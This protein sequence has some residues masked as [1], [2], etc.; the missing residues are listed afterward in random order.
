[1]LTGWPAAHAD[2]TINTASGNGAGLILSATL[3]GTTVASAS[4]PGSVT[5]LGNTA[6]VTGGTAAVGSTTSGTPYSVSGS[7]ANL[8]LTGTTALAIPAHLLPITPLPLVSTAISA[9]TTLSASLLDA[10]ASFS[11]GTLVNSYGGVSD[12]KL[13]V[14][15]SSTTTTTTPGTPPMTL[16]GGLFLPPST[17]KTPLFS[18]GLTADALQS[19]SQISLINGLLQGTNTLN[20][21]ANVSLDLSSLISLT[22]LSLP[23]SSL[24]RSIN[25]STIAGATP[26]AN[27]TLGGSTGSLLASLGIMLT[28]NEQFNTCTSLLTSCS[29]ETNALHLIIDPAI[30]GLAA[31][32]L[33]L[34][35]S[36]A[37]ATV[38]AVPEPATYA[39]MGLGLVGVMLGARRQRRHACVASSVQ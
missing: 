16:P 4:L 17:V 30:A 14:G 15:L 32:D 21:F 18:L 20:S 13:G 28:L 34:G 24:N 2:A 8:T 9:T 36:Y 25:L 11:N 23:G 6:S 27:T 10:A 7:V 26:V 3:L 5:I 33:K 12:L 22:S 31:V 39:M 37:A 19:T 35:H 1:M 29:V 38:S